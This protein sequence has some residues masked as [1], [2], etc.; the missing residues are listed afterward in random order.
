MS[1]SILVI[2]T[3]IN[4][5]QCPCLHRYDDDDWCAV[6]C[7]VIYNP[8]NRDKDCP[9][10]PVPEKIDIPDFDHSIKAESDNAFNVGAYMYN[11]GQYRGYN[12]CIDEILDI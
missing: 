11:R 2:D 5:I 8:R 7:N 9:L 12:Q 6:L 10:K 3:P 1:K 4:C